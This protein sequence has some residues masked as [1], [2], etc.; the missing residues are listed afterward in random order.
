M[1]PKRFQRLR[2]V[3]AAV[4]SL[5]PGDRAAYVARLRETDPEL[6]GELESLLEVE[7]VGGFLDTRAAPRSVWQDAI[8]EAADMTRTMRA[9][10]A[11]VIAGRY[12]LGALLGEGGFG[13]VYAASDRRLDGRRVVVKILKMAAGAVLEKRFQEEVR[14]LC[15][16][17]HPGIVNVTDSGR[18]E[19]G[20]AFLV[21]QYIDGPSLEQL[22]AREILAPERCLRLLRQVAEALGVAHEA[23]IL[24][25]D[26]KP[27]NIL[28]RDARNPRKERPVLIDFG[29]A[30]T[31]AA[32][33]AEVQTSV[34]TGTPG[35]MAPEQLIGRASQPTDLYALGVILFEMLTGRI[36]A[37][38]ANHGR[39]SEWIESALRG[40]GRAIPDYVI[41]AVCRTLEIDPRNRPQSAAEFIGM[42]QPRPEVA[43][44]RAI[45]A[46]G[47]AALLAAGWGA[48]TLRPSNP[49]RPTLVAKPPGRLTYTL[50]R[51]SVGGTED[52][53]PSQPVVAGDRLELRVHSPHTGFVYGFD[54]S[55]M[56]GQDNSRMVLLFPGVGGEPLP[57]ATEQR[58]PASAADWLEFDGASGSESVWLVWSARPVSFLEQVRPFAAAPHYGA[59]PDSEGEQLRRWLRQASASGPDVQV[60][61]ISLT[62]RT[63]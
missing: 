38:F 16:L 60:V 7:P 23:G 39:G 10:A 32:E 48:L 35:Y 29:I 36:P 18:L 22:R 20:S 63:P 34:V 1:T 41:R 47:G 8:D 2:E 55:E 26:L 61:R 58:I 11:A 62:L 4:E 28:I 49:A 51:R 33:T 24:H 50:G 21:M 12:E 19:D 5:A 3:F 45:I 27:S 37:A 59:V 15:R 17:D 46:A 54:E 44:R 13:R 40:S 6:A 53:E 57:A 25:R 14:A 30:R 31:D 9:P 42:L 52:I 43:R 56:P